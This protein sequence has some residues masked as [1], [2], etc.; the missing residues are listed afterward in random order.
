MNPLDKHPQVREALLL[1]QWIVTGLQ[2]VD[3]A[4]F[5]F[6]YQSP[7]DWPT[8]FL[9]SLAVTPVLWAYLGFSAQKNVT[10]TDTQGY[11]LGLPQK[12]KKS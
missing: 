12:E 2:T 7:D 3:S 6:M 5:F 4:L 11:P 1:L 10:G 9:G 8:W